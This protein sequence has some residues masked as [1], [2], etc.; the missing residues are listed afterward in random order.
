VRFV[1]SRDELLAVAHETPGSALPSFV[2]AGSGSS[3]R[4]PAADPGATEERRDPRLLLAVGL[5]AVADGIIHAVSWSPGIVVRRSIAV[6]GAVAAAVS[7]AD[8]VAGGGRTSTSTT[9]DVA[10]FPAREIVAQLAPTA[11][12][13]DAAHQSDSTARHVGVIASRAIVDAAGYGDPALVDDVAGD[14][15]LDSGTVGVLSPLAAR[16][17]SGL[18]V[19]CFEGR[20][21]RCTGG[22]DWFG[23]ASGWRRVRLGVPARAGELSPEALLRD[24]AVSVAAT[25]DEEVRRS[26]T[27]LTAELLR[28]VA[29]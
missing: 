1:L 5:H 28:A 2:A 14:F 22:D 29:R 7:R 17:P 9:F 18:R 16:Q 21:G 13:V 6:S 24:A 8:A 3:S 15:G 11:P 27:W 10:L 4:S 25:T 20:T 26:L 12:T 23:S 19:R